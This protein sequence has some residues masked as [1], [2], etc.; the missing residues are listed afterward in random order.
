MA[1]EYCWKRHA[2][3][4]PGS[5]ELDKLDR[6]GGSQWLSE[7]GCHHARIPGPVLSAQLLSCNG[8]RVGAW[9][10]IDR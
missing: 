4:Q 10:C 9:D 5:D 2:P 3:N 8:I 7:N 1:R 6:A